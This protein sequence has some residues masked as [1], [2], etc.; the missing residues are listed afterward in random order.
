[1][2][3]DYIDRRGLVGRIPNRRLSGDPMKESAGRDRW[4]CEVRA[5]IRELKLE[6]W[7][8]IRQVGSHRQFRHPTMSGTV[9]LPGNLGDE[10]ASET[11]GS[12][13]RQAGIARRPR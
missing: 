1:M 3:Q 9:T 11:V 7:V 12:V 10:L 5:L 4:G 6:G 2:F 8:Q 13:V